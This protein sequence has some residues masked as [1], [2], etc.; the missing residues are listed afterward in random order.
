LFK[1]VLVPLDGCLEAEAILP[2][3]S[4]LT[5]DLN[6]PVV[7]MTALDPKATG[8]TMARYEAS[9]SAAAPDVGKQPV[10][11]HPEL[12]AAT[13]LQEIA[14]RLKSEGLRAEYEVS[15]GHPAEEILRAAERHAC[16]LVALC[17]HG[18]SAIAPGVLGGVTAKVLYH[19]HLPILIV[20]PQPAVFEKTSRLIVPLDG[21][22]FGETALPYAA[23][24]AGK[25]S[26]PILLVRAYQE[27][28][29]YV[30]E[31]GM[32][33][34]TLSLQE[35][36]SAQSAEYLKRVG[37]ELQAEG[38]AVESHLVHGTP[39]QKI[40]EL[41]HS[42][43]H[44]LILMT[45]HGHSALARWLIGSVTETVVRTSE[46]PVLVIPRQY[47]R[48]YAL[49][50][51]EMLQ[52]VPVFSRLTPRDLESLAQTA[53]VQTFQ[54]SDFIVREGDPAGGFFIIIAGRVEVVKGPSGA[55]QS[56]LAT[57]GP[58]DFFGEMAI[59]DDQPRSASVRVVE[60]TECLTIRRSDFLTN[61]AAHPEIAVR[62]LPELVRRLREARER[63]VP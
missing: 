17:A 35:A 34:V 8:E 26:L 5:K 36:A 21:S 16:N 49:E 62:M 18:R 58:G 61:L 40:L 44:S 23:E 43:P 12:K 39:G 46:N 29:G 30:P 52:R 41:A 28:I 32:G 56:V 54:P 4:L 51:T 33:A 7:V 50:L 25:L 19:S 24:L 27:P 47:G 14:S 20:R 63:P 9:Q 55:Q 2:Y 53:R 1:K 48:R 42:Y 15:L 57:M 31:G 60:P 59:L 45:S 13:Y 11:I 3:V 38:L 6:V 37:E 10:P 22:E